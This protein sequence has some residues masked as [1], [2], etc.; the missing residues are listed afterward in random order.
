MENEQLT[1]GQNAKSEYELRRQKKLA[2]Q[3]QK[4]KT[5]TTKHIFKIALIALIAGGGIAVF[6]WYIARQP[7]APAGSSSEIVARNGI[8]WHPE[9][10]ITIKGQKQEISANIGIG[11]THQPVHTHDTTGVIHLEISGRVIEDDIKL[12]KF[13]G[14]W[15]KQFNSNCV[16]DSCNGPDGKVKMLVNG[17]ENTEFENYRMQDKDKI[18]IIY[19]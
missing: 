12:G 10:T 11:V 17:Q 8:H 6:G 5:K 14:I 2:D 3:S 4:Q 7:Q 18:E 9:L 1:P 13:F 16:F 15:D 19:E